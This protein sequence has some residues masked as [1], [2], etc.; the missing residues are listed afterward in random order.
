LAWIARTL[1]P[2]SFYTVE[3]GRLILVHFTRQT[4]S[5]FRWILVASATLALS[6]V[7]SGAVSSTTATNQKITASKLVGASRL[8]EPAGCRRIQPAVGVPVLSVR[9]V[10]LGKG[11]FALVSVCIEGAGPFPFLI[12]SGSALSVVDTQLARRLH[13][14]QVGAPER[15]AGIGRSA[16]VVPEQVSS[17]S[18][19]GLSLSPQVVL[20]GSLPNLDAN[21]PL[22]GVIGSDVLS[23]FGSVRIDYRAQTMSLGLAESP[24]PAGNGVTQG[25]TSTPTPAR[26]LK[27]MRVDVA[28]R[29]VTRLGAVGVYA[30]I[31]LDGSGAQLF[32]VDT[33]AEIS[34]VSPQLTRSLHMVAAHQSVFLPAAFG[35]PVTLTEV[36]SGRWALGSTPL[37]PQPIATLRASGL[38]ADGLLG[39]D[40]L[41]RYGAVVIDY[42][43][44]RML[45]GSG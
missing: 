21:Q 44:A 19:D 2:S 15:A 35:C 29:I 39:S 30:P 26:F 22:A 16:T 28:L 11:A 23:R 24:S 6:F 38:K 7:T 43:G 31:K 12:D 40:V 41:S 17:W 18:A 45:L 20:S 36:Q 14:R 3:T 42:R 27:G 9:T 1:R 32:V 25:P 8:G 4:L 37:E 5:V 34:M 33:G 13:L 10:C